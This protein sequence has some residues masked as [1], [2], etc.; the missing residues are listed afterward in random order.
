MSEVKPGFARDWIEFT[1]P[2][3]PE[4]IFKCD[5]TWLTSSWTCTYGNGCKGVFADRPNDGCCTEGAMYSDAN[6]EER[7]REAA[8]YLTPDMWQFYDEA[9]PKKP[10]G[11]LRITD[12]DEDNER[13]TRTVNDACI[14]L[15]RK[16]YE[17]EG[18]TGSFGCVLHHLA[19]KRGMHFADVKP[20]V[21][22]QL[23]LRRSYET[24]EVGER[25]YTITVLG[26]YER[27]AWGD[28]G[29]DF[30]W[31]CTS[32]SDA[33]IGK[34]PVYLSNKPELVKLM[35][36]DAY[37]ILASHCDQRMESIR[38][39]KARSLPVFVIRHPATLLA[40]ESSH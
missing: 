11:Q 3:N 24:R 34:E 2:N 17:A 39:S 16:G 38:E 28:G 6:D 21:C 36:E 29:E 32:N 40:E 14:F 30:D 18:F 9:R 26:E 27:L 5:L 33:H 1:D 37:A 22:W 10:G 13:K 20:D 35:G 15:N 23:P 8:G 19:E 4:E 25:T 12:L 7:V 31:Y